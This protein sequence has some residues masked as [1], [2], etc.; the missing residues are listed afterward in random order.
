MNVYRRLLSKKTYPAPREVFFTNMMASTLSALHVHQI[1]NPTGHIV[2]RV[3]PGGD[4]FNVYVL[5]DTNEDCAIK[6]ISGPF[7]S[8]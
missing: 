7:Q 4:E 5:D 6:A 1:K 3:R 8:H 2:V